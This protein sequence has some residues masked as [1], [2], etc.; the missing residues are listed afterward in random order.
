MEEDHVRLIY[1]AVDGSVHIPDL[2][3]CKKDVQYLKSELVVIKTLLYGQSMIMFLLILM[4]ILLM[5]WPVR[6]YVVGSLHEEILQS[7]D[8]SQNLQIP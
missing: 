3:S 4:I 7:K 8:I 5:S 2:Q 1:N 6:I